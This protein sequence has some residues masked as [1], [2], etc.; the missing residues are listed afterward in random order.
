MA[1]DIFT[2]LTDRA[3]SEAY[4]RLALTP[5]PGWSI[6]G[7]HVDRPGV[8][9]EFWGA[10]GAPD[11]LPLWERPI[12]VR[13]ILSDGSPGSV[14]AAVVALA[15]ARCENY[16]LPYTCQQDGGRHPHAYYGAESYCWPCQLRYVLSAPVQ[17]PSGS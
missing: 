5:P 4:G 8:E 7:T 13:K 9:L 2:S 14:S 15:E 12:G 3:R 10:D 1:E 16:T 6:Y 11:G 17:Y